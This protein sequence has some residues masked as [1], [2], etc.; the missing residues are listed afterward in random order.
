MGVA[1]K[2]AEALLWRHKRLLP[3]VTS[4][5]THNQMDVSHWLNGDTGCCHVIKQPVSLND[6]FLPKTKEY[7]LNERVPNFQLP[8]KFVSVPLSRFQENLSF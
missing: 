1:E 7:I 3:L 8:P 5:G 4:Q 2:L 6:K